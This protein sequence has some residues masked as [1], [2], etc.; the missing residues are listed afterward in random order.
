MGSERVVRSSLGGWFHV[1][2][3]GK[4]K[5]VDFTDL[6]RREL[7]RI[8]KRFGITF[9]GDE[10]PTNEDLVL[11]LESD[12]VAAL[13]AADAELA[14]ELKRAQAWR[15]RKVT[16]KGAP[17]DQDR[18]QTIGRLM[19]KN[20]ISD[21][22]AGAADEIARIFE[23][24]EGAALA[25]FLGRA[26][27]GGRS[28]KDRSRL[29]MAEWVADGFLTRFEPWR[30]ELGWRFSA[31]QERYEREVMAARERGNGPRSVKR[32]EPDLY[33]VTIMV[34]AGGLSCGKVDKLLGLRNGTAE[35]GLI[36]ALQMFV[37]ITSRR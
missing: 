20:V 4:S 19:R 15:D 9:E 35:A 13:A 3:R 10:P 25:S 16:F 32:P 28:G 1:K 14:R 31:D 6:T 8:A 33:A 30:V 18:G 24:R 36:E 26:T 37:A 23:A 27:Q 5:G 7:L 12:E 2:R 34:V 22:E 11:A 29:E 17:R 21:R